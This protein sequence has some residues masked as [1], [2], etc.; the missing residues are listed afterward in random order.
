MKE[1]G[2]GEV[3]GVIICRNALSHFED[4]F[5]G[6]FGGFVFFDSYKSKLLFFLMLES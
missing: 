6:N 1:T 3:E 2:R 4:T 5:H